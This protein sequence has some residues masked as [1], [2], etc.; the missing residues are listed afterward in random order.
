ML[1]SS[2]KMA[3]IVENPSNDNLMMLFNSWMMKSISWWMRMKTVYSDYIVTP[4]QQWLNGTRTSLCCIMRWN[5]E[6]VGNCFILKLKIKF[7]EIFPVTE[8]SLDKFVLIYS[9]HKLRYN[10]IYFYTFP[11]K[12]FLHKRILKAEESLTFSVY[13][14]V[15]IYRI[16]WIMNLYPSKKC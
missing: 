15:G 11:L 12:M 7:P 4:I 3:F 10:C 13:N 1:W 9:A 5:C 14:F 16:L 6:T 8:L 2:W